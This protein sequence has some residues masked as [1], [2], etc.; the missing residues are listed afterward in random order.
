MDERPRPDID[1]VRRALRE[2]DTEAAEDE[3]VRDEPE[4]PAE[5]NDGDT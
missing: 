3:E 4:E 1:R 2:H 5:D